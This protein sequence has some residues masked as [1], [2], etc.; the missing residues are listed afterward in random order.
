M[1]PLGC[2]V[3]RAEAKLQRRGAGG[4]APGRSSSPGRW[5][6]TGWASWARNG[7]AGALRAGAG[8][9]AALGLPELWKNWHWGPARPSSL[10]GPHQDG[11]LMPKCLRSC[12]RNTNVSTVWGMRRMPAGKRPWMGKGKREVARPGRNPGPPPPQPGP[13]PRPAKPCKRPW[14][15]VSQSPWRSGERPVE[16]DKESNKKKSRPSLKRH[17]GTP[18]APAAGSAHS[19]GCDPMASADHGLEYSK[20]NSGQ[21]VSKEVTAV[22]SADRLTADEAKPEPLRAHPVAGRPAWHPQRW[23]LLTAGRGE[24]GRGRASGARRTQVLCAPRAS[25]R[26]LVSDLKRPLADFR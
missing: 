26:A 24:K 11:T 10:P 15:R 4:T 1:A 7:G 23:G 20:V 8:L 5:G 6:R 18:P 9:R 21:H 16:N 25:Q 22:L 12:S 2:Q 19:R 14:A 3:G 13:A 17:R